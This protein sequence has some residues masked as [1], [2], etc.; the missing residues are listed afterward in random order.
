MT[1]PKRDC[2][3]WFDDD[4]RRVWRRLETTGVLDLKDP[5]AVAAYCFTLALW[6]RMRGV[7]DHLREEGSSS[8]L[9]RDGRER[10]HPAL[11]VEARLAADLLELSEALDLEPSGRPA[12]KPSRVIFVDEGV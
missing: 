10:S 5:G 1:R 3:S 12:A 6:K 4:A 8:W 9:T 11:G 7:I 2:P